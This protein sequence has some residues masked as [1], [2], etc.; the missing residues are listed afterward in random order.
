MRSMAPQSVNMGTVRSA[1]SGHA[2]RRAEA[3]KGLRT[4]GHAPHRPTYQA[5]RS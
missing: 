2:A 3:V 1:C 4:G 5:S